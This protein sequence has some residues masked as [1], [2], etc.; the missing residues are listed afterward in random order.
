MMTRL[1]SER[2]DATQARWEQSGR[3]PAMFPAEPA[4]KALMELALR[5]QLSLMEAALEIHLDEVTARKVFLRR[6]LPWDRADHIA[7]ALGRHPS[8][9]WPDWY[10]PI[11]A[12][13]LFLQESSSLLHARTQE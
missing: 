8:E 2:S 4:R 13:F 5:R 3:P 6:W 9:L 12:P 11:P 10:G 1:G 7:V